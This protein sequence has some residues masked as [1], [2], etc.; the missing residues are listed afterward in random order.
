[1]TSDMGAHIRY[2]AGCQVARSFFHWTSRL[3][4]DAFDKVDW[5][6]VHRT[7]NKKVPRL[8]LVWA[9]KEVM[10]IAAANKNLRRRH[11]NRWSNKCHCCTIHVEMAEHILLSP[12]EGRIEAFRLATTA[13]EWWLKEADTDPDLADCIVEYMQRWGTVTMEEIV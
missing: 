5:P 7:L 1:M 13:L 2:A 10:N 6:Q 9:C 11:R 12:K 8:F 4:T 3:F